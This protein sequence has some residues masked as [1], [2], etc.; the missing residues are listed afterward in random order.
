MKLRWKHYM[1]QFQ[2]QHVKFLLQTFLLLYVFWKIPIKMT[3]YRPNK[4]YLDFVA[5][6]L[7]DDL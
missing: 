3:S 7:E 2:Q 1:S 4:L 6:Y 5:L